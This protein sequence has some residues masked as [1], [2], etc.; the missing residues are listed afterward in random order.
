MSYGPGLARFAVRG[1]V[2]NV[3]GS[4][5]PGT[6]FTVS[7]LCP[8]GGGQPE[9]TCEQWEELQSS[10]TLLKFLVLFMCQK[11]LFFL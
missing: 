4:K 11:M 3:S 5:G 2:V 7:R 1:E 6:S 9:T 10:K 8:C